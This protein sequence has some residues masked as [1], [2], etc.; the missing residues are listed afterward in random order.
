ME[1]DEHSRA[2]E[3]IQRVLARRMTTSQ[4]LQVAGLVRPEVVHVHVRELRM[5]LREEVDDTLELRLLLLAR[6]C[7]VRRVLVVFP[8][9]EEV[10]EPFPERER[11]ALDVKEK[12][13]FVRLRK[14]R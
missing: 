11:I 8:D 6:F 14:G 13:T 9:P 2:E 10:L 3:L 1:V 4:A 5:P 7:P 12:I